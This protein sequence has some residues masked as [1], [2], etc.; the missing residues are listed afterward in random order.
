MLKVLNI[1]KGKV[2]DGAARRNRKT[3]GQP[4]HSE[5]VRDYTAAMIARN[6]PFLA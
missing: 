5:T 6:R 2:H 1:G 4:T 3:A